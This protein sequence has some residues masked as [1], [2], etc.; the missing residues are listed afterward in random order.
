MT[1]SSLS[2]EDLIVHLVDCRDNLVEMF[3]R[4]HVFTIP[5][6]IATGHYL[7]QTCQFA[8]ISPKE[9]L[10]LLKGSSPVSAGIAADE[11]SKL[12]RL[13]DQEGMGPE[14]FSGKSAAQVLESLQSR[15][16]SIGAAVKEYLDLVGYQLASGYDIIERYMLELPELLVGNI[17]SARPSQKSLRDSRSADELTQSL[18]A[19]VPEDRRADFD[20][21]LEEARHMN[22]LRDE[23]GV[24][25]E[26]RAVG[27]VRRAVLEA[28]QRL[29]SDGR[30]EDG[31]DLVH[32]SHDE[33]VSLLQGQP[34]PSSA[35]LQSRRIWCEEKSI[36]DAPPFL[37]PAPQPP[38][39]PEAL[40]EMARMAE[41]ALGAALG[42]LFDHPEPEKAAD[43]G[44]S[45]LPASPGVYEG[46]ARLIKSP[47]DFQS[48]EH[49]DVLVTRNTSATFAVL[50]LLGA[51]VSDRGGQLSHA[52]I[53]SREYGI[54]GVVSTRNASRKIPDGA[55]VRV[56]GDAGTV[57]VL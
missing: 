10:D 19:K 57:E 6:I 44:V 14:Q 36:E 55:R 53:V 15:S 37:G 33:I 12:G 51:I 23:R 8:P 26:A 43:A 27:L 39:P 46:R 24:Y 48:I 9:A 30:L 52:A 18:R 28:G 21:L 38:P 54:P 11:L 34:G 29:Q 45:G 32:A 40:P 4:H 35:E 17:W 50:P 5:S 25:N 2:S 13:L 7:A 49:G 3:Y 56:D 16:G 41:R 22:R 31:S 42:N 47:A 20:S 1:P